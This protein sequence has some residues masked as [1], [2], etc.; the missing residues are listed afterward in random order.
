M[1]QF[2]QLFPNLQQ[3]DFYFSGESYAGKYV[4]SACYKIW[5]MS[6]QAGTVKIPL[7]GISIGDGIMDPQTQTQGIAKQAYQFGMFNDNERQI[8]LAYE[9]AISKRK[10]FLCILQQI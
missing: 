8:G 1:S 6:Q 3:N 9:A 7:V 10:A 4:P 5:Q 2:F